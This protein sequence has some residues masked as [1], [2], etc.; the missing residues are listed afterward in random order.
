MT[1]LIFDLDNTT[2]NSDARTPY[3][4]NGDLDLTMY[5]VMQTRKNIFKDKLLPLAKV[6]RSAYNRGFEVV[7]L[8]A[9]EMTKADYDYLN[10]HNLKAHLILSRNNI[11]DAHFN[12][13]DSLYK[14]QHVKNA[15]IDIN[16][17]IMYDDNALV[18]KV[19]R[20]NGLNVQCAHKINARLKKA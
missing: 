9:R 15:N 13:T 11:T 16:N 1:T 12:L 18:K 2:I 5:K 20:L 7:I 8:T 10:F 4:D 3:F 19:L 6:M 17:S 14:L